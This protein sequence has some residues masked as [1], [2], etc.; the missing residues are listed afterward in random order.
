M[1][2]RRFNII[3]LSFA[4]VLGLC[5]CSTTGKKNKFSALR[6]HLETARDGTDRNK[7][8]PLFRDK[9]QLVNIESSPFLSEG[10]VSEARIVEAVGGFAVEIQFERRGAW[11]LE[12]YS[13][14]NRGRR[15]AIYAEF[16]DPADPKQ[17]INRWIAAPL[18]QKRVTSGILS[19]TPDATRAEAEEFVK[20]LNLLAKKMEKSW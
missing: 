14:A 9:S 16:K 8:V 6:I 13:T 1:D 15:F 3:L 10:N 5:A 7:P 17:V 12:T 11:L 19:F 20:G 2:W 4:V 18:I